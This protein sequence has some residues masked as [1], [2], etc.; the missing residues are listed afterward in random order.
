[1]IYFIH[2]LRYISHFF[3]H[4]VVHLR[5]YFSKRRAAMRKKEAK[6][7]L[8]ACLKEQV[9]PKSLIPT[10]YNNF[11]QDPFPEIYR[12]LLTNRIATLSR[13]IN[14]DYKLCKIHYNNL[15]LLLPAQIFTTSI[16]VVNLNLTRKIRKY[17]Q[18]LSEKMSIL[19]Y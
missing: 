15:H 17:N 13:E 6:S 19:C 18:H 5:A 2:I 8:R 3:P 10:N 7:F 16:D 9:I 12:I 1:M 14:Y 11:K 4:A